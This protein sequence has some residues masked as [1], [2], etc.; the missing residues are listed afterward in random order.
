MEREGSTMKEVMKLKLVYCD[1]KVF[2][3]YT[4]LCE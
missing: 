3:I 2:S 4:V 1:K